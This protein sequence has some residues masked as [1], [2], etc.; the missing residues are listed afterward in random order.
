MITNPEVI[1]RSHVITVN[2][3]VAN[4]LMNEKKVPLLGKNQYKS[5][6]YFAKTFEVELFMKEMPFYLKLSKYIV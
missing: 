4:Y 1:P 2:G 6:F 5:E 3:V